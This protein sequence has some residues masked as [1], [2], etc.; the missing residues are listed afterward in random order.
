MISQQGCTDSNWGAPCQNFCEGTESDAAGLHFLW[1]CDG[2]AHCCGN[3]RSS[4]CCEDPGVVT[5]TL[6]IGH[7]FHRP[8]SSSSSSSSTTSE[9][10]SSSTSTIVS[11]SAT[12]VSVMDVTSAASPTSSQASS[13][14]TADSGSSG[15]YT[16]N[17]AIGLGVGIPLGLGVI[18]AI[19]FLGIQ[20]RKKNKGPAVAEIVSS[21]N[22]PMQPYPQQY[23]QN[24]SYPTQQPVATLHTGASTYVERAE[25]PW[26][27]QPE[28]QELDTSKFT[29][30][31]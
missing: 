26:D 16:R 27:Q 14:P 4:T 12:F 15:D 5:F 7:D 18:G 8:P 28:P 6:D 9:I 31:T 25:M 17:M 2:Q 11:P 3:N 24:W 30:Y 21:Q 1:R 23:P 10:T 19:C 20:M 29:T 22:P 13:S